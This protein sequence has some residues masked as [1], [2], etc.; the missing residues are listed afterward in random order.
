MNWRK[1]GFEWNAKKAVPLVYEAIKLDCGFSADL[2]VDGKLIVELNAR[3]AFILSMRLNCSR[4][5][6]S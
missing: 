4:T 3:D 6:A 1:L 2:V 5:C